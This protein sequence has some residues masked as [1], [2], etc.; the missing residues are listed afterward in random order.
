L[1]DTLAGILL[2]WDGP[3][4]KAGGTA[5]ANKAQMARQLV[6]SGAYAALCVWQCFQIV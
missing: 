2:A 6:E 5:A 4:A 3:D 1:Q